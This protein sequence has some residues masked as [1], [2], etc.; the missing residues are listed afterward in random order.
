L[1]AAYGGGYGSPSGTTGA[2]G[3]S[4]EV[5]SLAFVL[6]AFFVLAYLA[7]RVK[8]RR[9][10]QFEMF[11]FA[12]VLGAAEVPKILD[13]LSGLDLGVMVTYGLEVH[14]LSM[15]IL[16]GFVGYRIYGFFRRKTVAFK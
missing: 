14:S 8:T 5:L 9:S 10:F 1:L 2:L 7:V 11:V 15:V 3:T 12:L 4:A 16:A 6:A 13:D